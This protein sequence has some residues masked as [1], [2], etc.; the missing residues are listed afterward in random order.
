MATQISE[1][2]ALPDPVADFCLALNVKDRQQ[3]RQAAG[4]TTPNVAR[5]RRL[6][7]AGLFNCDRIFRR[8]SFASR[9]LAISRQ[10]IWRLGRGDRD[11]CCAAISCNNSG[12]IAAGTRAIF[13]DDRTGGGVPTMVDL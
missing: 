12:Y 7:D 4:A 1:F 13:N 9:R 5:H 6:I 8:L 3:Y 2:G 10:S 11:W